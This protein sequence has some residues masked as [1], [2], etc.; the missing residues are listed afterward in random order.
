MIHVGDAL[1][2]LRTMPDESVHCCVTSPPYFGLRDYGTGTWEGGDPACDHKQ[3]HGIQGKNGDRQDR[4]FTGEG[5]Y[6]QQCAKCGGLRVDQQLGLERTYPEYIA[7]LVEVFI[8][9][10]RVLLPDGTCWLNI[11]DSYATGAG[12]VGECPGGGEQ[13]ERWKGY[14][15][16]HDASPKH[17][18][19]GPMTQA[20]RLPQPNLK[21]KDIM[22]IP[23]RRAIA[24]QD[25]GWYLRSDIIW[26]KPNPMPES[27]TDRPTKSH[28]YLFLLAK[29]ERYYYD[30]E[31]IKENSTGTSHDR[32]RKDR[33]DK[34]PNAWSAET[35]RHDGVG[36]GRFTAKV[37]KISNPGSGIKYNESFNA[38]VTQTVDTR[39]KRSVWTIATKAND[40]AET[41]R[42]VRVEVDAPCDGSERITSPD[43]PL[44]ADRPV[45]ASN[46][47]CGEHAADGQSRNGRTSNHLVP[48]QSTDSAPTAKR[49]A[50]DFAADSS[51]FDPQLCAHAAIGHNRQTSRTGHAP[52]TNP[53]CTPSAQTPADIERNGVEPESCD[54]VEHTPASSTSAGCAS[55]GE[56][57]SEQTRHRIAGSCTCRHY[58]TKTEKI[59][60][61]ATFP[62]ALVEPCIKAGCP[63]GGIVLDPFCGSGTTGVVAERFGRKFVGIELNLEYAAMAER[64]IAG[65]MPLLVG[66]S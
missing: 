4:T 40:W 64:R 6:K 54:L 39:N 50:P 21:P 62:E 51:D 10:R 27:M 11:G 46:G 32:A 65:V 49:R 12:N 45:L 30:A 20:N 14:R 33:P 15:G 29:N 3:N 13:G 8:E 57:L 58:I 25:S 18:A 1:T 37:N 35:G 16:V 44:H 36:N 7:K 42:R 5:I 47:V 23:A 22:M 48:V 60:H 26:H 55:D 66:F 38:A 24:L 17:S 56:G 59:A 9:V 28:E 61:F 41:S 31:A 43:C 19:I 2:V 63:P 53:P 52:G 34:W